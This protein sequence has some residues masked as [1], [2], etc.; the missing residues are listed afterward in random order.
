[1]H[2]SCPVRVIWVTCSASVA[3]LLGALVLLVFALCGTCKGRSNESATLFVLANIAASDAIFAGSWLAAMAGQYRT[4]VGTAIGWDMRVIGT[5][6][7]DLGFVSGCVWTAALA[8]FLYRALVVACAPNFG[9]SRWAVAVCIWGG[10]LALVVA[11]AFSG[12]TDLHTGVG[13]TAESAVQDALVVTAE[14]LVPTCTIAFVLCKYQAL[15]TA[16]HAHAHM[17]NE[18]LDQRHSG[19]PYRRSSIAAKMDRRLATYLGAFVLCQAPSLVLTVLEL[20]TVLD[21]S[22]P[23][24]WFW[25]L[26]T[27]QPFQGL[28]NM[29]VF[30]RHASRQAGPW[31]EAERRG[32]WSCGERHS[33]EYDEGDDATCTRTGPIRRL[34]ARV[35]GQPPSEPPSRT[36][37][38]GMRP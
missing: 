28:V 22:R 11:T 18:H 12:N 16:F 4:M 33:A 13:S 14:V 24:T 10:S 20:L 17:L 35:A 27:V 31:T 32:C 26:Y 25:W 1:M 7:A 36:A 29:I 21:R 30:L 38:F 2:S 37:P 23:P 9:A 34:I 8:W 6:G 15:R 19:G 5:I 3:S